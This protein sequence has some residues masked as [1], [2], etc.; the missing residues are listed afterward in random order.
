MATNNIEIK[1]DEKTY[2]EVYEKFRVLYEMSDKIAKNMNS[3]ENLRFQI[4]VFLFSNIIFLV[5]G[6]LA[7]YFLT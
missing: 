6:M 5:V 1:I 3:I 2:K 4:V 7:G